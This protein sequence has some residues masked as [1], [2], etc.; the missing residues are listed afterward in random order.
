MQ[1]ALHKQS[2]MKKKELEKG[3]QE[4]LEYMKIYDINPLDFKP[5]TTNIK[6][7]FKEFLYDKKIKEVLDKAKSGE[8]RENYIETIV[9]KKV[10]EKIFESQLILEWEQYKKIPKTNL[11]YRYD[12]G[13]TNT[14]T[15]DHIHVY[16]DDN[17][18]YSINRSGTP[19]DG[20]KA[21]LSKKEMKFLKSIG[22]TP[23]ADGI[24]EWINL[25]LEETYDAIKVDFLLD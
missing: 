17:Q 5:S 13:N 18:L 6:S 2:N 22:F 21:Q 16:Y 15:Q 4:L 12:S 23:P 20:S 3:I 25:D 7:S 24:L 19:H 1:K 11:V 14:K 8:Y 9:F 10:P